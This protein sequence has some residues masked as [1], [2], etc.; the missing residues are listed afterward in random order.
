MTR[1]CADT[2][3]GRVCTDDH[4]RRYRNGYRP[5][6]Y[7]GYGGGYGYNS[8][9]N[10][11]PECNMYRG[12]DRI[13][14]RRDHRREEEQHRNGVRRYDDR[15]YRPND[16]RP[17]YRYESTPTPSA[18]DRN[19]DIAVPPSR[20]PLR[21]EMASNGTISLG[22]LKGLLSRQDFDQNEMSLLLGDANDNN[23]LDNQAALR[24]IFG[25]EVKIGS[26]TDGPEAPA[27][28]A[29]MIQDAAG[30]RR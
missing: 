29:R 24:K 3:L 13:R 27:L 6:N 15:Y 21:D 5:Y 19:G 7:N 18:R 2:P 30:Q 20:H 11:Y 26:P 23:K 12:G 22:E 8:Y 17:D 1:I 28:A 4:P 25:R 14:C 10:E 9:N 16:Y